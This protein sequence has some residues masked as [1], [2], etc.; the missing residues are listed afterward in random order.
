MKNGIFILFLILVLSCK[1]KRNVV[2]NEPIG[3]EKTIIIISPSEIEVEIK[4]RAFDLGTRLLSTCNTSKF[5]PFSIDEATEK[6][7][8]NATLDKIAETC[9]KINFRNGKFIAI[10]LI[11]IF[12]NQLTNQYIFRY[13]IDYEKKYFKR[14][15]T[16]VV[17]QD[18]RV[19]AITTKEIKPKPM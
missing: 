3:A 9:K 7:I 6:V 10:D 12:H 1:A 15:L 11:D 4:L 2:Q 8:Q 17:D 18:S 19:S 14:E 5:K 13:T 16:V